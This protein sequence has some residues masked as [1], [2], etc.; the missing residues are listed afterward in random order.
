MYRWPSLGVGVGLTQDL[1]GHRGDISL[2][3]DDEASQV[4]QWVPLGPAEVGVRFLP[5]PV[6]DGQQRGRQPV[7]DGRA[8]R[9]PR[10]VLRMKRES[11]R[12]GVG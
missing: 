1:A 2:A 10:G 4:L 11:K 5:C 8:P 6:A 7:G 3:K 9:D 12:M